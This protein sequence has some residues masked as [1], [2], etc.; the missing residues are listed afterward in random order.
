MGRTGLGVVSPEGGPC[1]APPSP[2]MRKDLPVSDGGGEAMAS[3]GTFEGRATALASSRGPKV[4]Y[5]SSSF[6]SFGKGRTGIPRPGGGVSG[7]LSE[8]VD[9]VRWLVMILLL[10]GLA[11]L[12]MLLSL[13]FLGAVFMGDWLVSKAVQSYSP[14]SPTSSSLSSS[15]SSPTISSFG[16]AVLIVRMG[17]FT[18]LFGV[19]P[20]AA[21]DFLSEGGVTT[22][23]SCID[24]FTEGSGR[25]IR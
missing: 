6:S 21:A 24:E 12:I 18:L 16:S 1:F 8:S 10:L 15:L 2:A 5:I 23:E 3:V 11:L 4:A 17:V 7:G 13:A 14:P 9:A 22:R 20:A 25:H 19:V